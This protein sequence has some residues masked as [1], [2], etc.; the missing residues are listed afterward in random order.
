M[1]CMMCVKTFLGC[2]IC[3]LLIN[4]TLSSPVFAQRGDRGSVQPADTLVLNDEQ[5]EYP[6]GL[7]LEILEDPRA[8]LTIEDVRSAEYAAQ[9]VPSRQEIPN[10]GFSDSAFWLRFRIRNQALRHREWYLELDFPNMHHISLYRPRPF[11]PGGFEEYRTGMLHP[12]SGREVSSH[13]LTFKLM[14]LTDSDQTLF[15]R[16]E[17]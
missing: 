15:L 17:S 12:F 2:I 11:N 16:C 1:F 6:L 4:V 7:F 14:P 13:R 8:E 5:E 3:L 9:F 10:F